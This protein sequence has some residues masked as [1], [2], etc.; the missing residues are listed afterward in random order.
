MNSFFSFYI[1][2][3]I[4]I[5][6]NVKCLLERPDGIYSFRLQNERVFYASERMIKLAA[7]I[8]RDNLI[9]FGTCIGKFTKTRKFRLNITA[10]EFMAPYAKVK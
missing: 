4:S 9:S 7:T 1:I 2:I 10:L 8:A 3:K 6:E 5:G